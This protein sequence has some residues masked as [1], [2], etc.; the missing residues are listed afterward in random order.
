M[1]PSQYLKNSPYFQKVTDPKSSYS[2]NHFQIH[3]YSKLSVTS[4]R[5]WMGDPA[6][7]G[8][9]EYTI[10]EIFA[11][12]DLSNVATFVNVCFQNGI[13]FE[14]INIFKVDKKINTSVS[15]DV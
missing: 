6:G 8:T 13:P 4:E 10:I 3:I 9:D 15:I 11:T 2:T 12:T 7:V 14:N 5:T 1:N